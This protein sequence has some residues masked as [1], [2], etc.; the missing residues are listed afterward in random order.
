MSEPGAIVVLLDT[1]PASEAALSAAARLAHHRNL[2]LV[3]LFIEERDLLHSAAYPFAHEIS[4]LSGTSRPFDSEILRS[5]LDLQRR[6]IE[7]QLQQEAGALSLT[8]RLHVETGSVQEALAGMG[9]RAEI[10][11]LGKTGWSGSHGRRLGASATQVISGT[12]CTIVL[13][14]GTPWPARGPVQALIT[15]PDSGPAIARMAAVLA[16]VADR[17]L[18]LL[19]APG[20][21]PSREPDVLAAL[22]PQAAPVTVER[23][24]VASPAALARSLRRRPGGEL[25]IGRSGPAALGCDLAELVTLTDTPVVLVPAT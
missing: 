5:R 20:L 4:V 12:D 6:R 19:F 22:G 24:G 25:V 8:W 9:I 3:G 21:D 2:E 16:G 15:D 17:P 10:L 14:E 1:S 7:R 13:W 23:L 11:L 18:H